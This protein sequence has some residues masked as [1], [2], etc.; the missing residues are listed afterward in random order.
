MNLSRI[1][2]ELQKFTHSLYKHRIVIFVVAFFVSYGFLITRISS[3][4]QQEPAASTTEQA[5]KRL[6]ID[7][8]SIEK[9]E[10]LEDQNVQVRALFK[11]ARQNPFSE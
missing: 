2:G 9:I 11:D 7:K 6:T 3:Y 1:T 10:D 4:T 5:I 8:E